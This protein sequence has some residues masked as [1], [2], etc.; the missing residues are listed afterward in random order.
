MM[1]WESLFRESSDLHSTFKK[2]LLFWK[3]TLCYV[4][5][6]VTVGIGGSVHA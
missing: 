6:F 4:I 2:L 5:V 3:F 1:V